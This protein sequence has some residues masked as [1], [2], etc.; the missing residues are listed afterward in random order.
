LPSL[1]FDALDLAEPPVDRVSG[2]QR[3]GCGKDLI[4]R[5]ACLASGKEQPELLS[6]GAMG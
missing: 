6:V 1:P 3:P 2:P 4:D 5:H